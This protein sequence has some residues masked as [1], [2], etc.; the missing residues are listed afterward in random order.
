ME[1]SAIDDILFFGV[2]VLVAGQKLL[3]Y[4]ERK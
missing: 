4:L 3:G 2:S 1:P